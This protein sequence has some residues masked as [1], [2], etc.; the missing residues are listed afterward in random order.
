MAPVS[1][2]SPVIINAFIGPKG[3][4]QVHCFW[5]LDLSVEEEGLYE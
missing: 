5:F 2:I 3:F 1:V 4:P